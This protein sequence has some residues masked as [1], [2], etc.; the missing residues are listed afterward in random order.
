MFVYFGPHSSLSVQGVYSV[1]DQSL[2]AKNHTCLT[3]TNPYILNIAS[4]HILMEILQGGNLLP[5]KGGELALMEIVQG[6]E[7]ALMEIVL[8][9]ESALID[10]E[11]VQS[12]E[13]ALRKIERGSRR[14][15]HS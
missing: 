5:W 13:H 4:L 11:I 15:R 9:W 1:S 14:S 6:W 2:N 3:D 8:G 7:L 10:L 12:W